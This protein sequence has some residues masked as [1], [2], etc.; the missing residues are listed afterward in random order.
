MNKYNRSIDYQ[1]M[2]ESK[3]RSID[4]VMN[5][6]NRPKISF[7]IR[8]KHLMSMSLTMFLIA[9]VFVLNTGNGS[10]IK[11]GVTLNAASI[12]QITEVTYISGNLLAGEIL[13]NRSLLTQ[14]SNND[15]T[16]FEGDIDEFNMYFDVLKI[17]L[18]DNAI[19]IPVI[20]EYLGEEFQS[21]LTYTVGSE[22]Y[23]F[24]INTDGI[25]ISGELIIG[26]KVYQVSG[27]IIE[28]I[29]E[30][31]VELLSRS[32][33]NYIKISYEKEF[34]DETSTQYKI[35]SRINGISK[36]KEIKVSKSE[37][38]SKVEINDNNNEYSLKKELEETGYVYKIEYKIGD[39]SGEAKIVE[40]IVNGQN[41]YT[42][43]ISEDGIQKEINKSDPH[44]FGRDEREDKGKSSNKK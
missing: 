7:K 40:T 19:N 1:K 34:S 28:T 24:N 27:T 29:N 4:F 44:Q 3:N 41:Q 30:S 5:E 43:K 20:T 17:F 38:E 18:D 15:I 22:I 33:D 2:N 37:E 35:E 23:I 39:K 42:Y 11:T 36:E 12:D 32:G 14:L 16:E 31:E 21:T 13:A 10:D 6:I 8:T 26:S 9:F 25:N